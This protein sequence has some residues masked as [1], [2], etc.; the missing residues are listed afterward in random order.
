MS[1][2]KDEEREH[3]IRDEI[4]VDAYDAEEQALS[5]YYSIK[6]RIWFPF[7][8]R[9][10]SE[11]SISPLREGEEVTVVG[12]PSEEDCMVEMVVMVE[13]EGRTFGVPL[14]QL[15]PVEV[16]EETEQIIADWHYWVEQGYRLR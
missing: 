9:C 7:R 11:R 15:E 14:A 5:W 10:I 6:D 2:E 4:V 13:W 16:N 1:R 8:A 12:M 3:R